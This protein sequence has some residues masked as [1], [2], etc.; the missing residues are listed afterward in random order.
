MNDPIEVRVV[1]NNL[2]GKD[3]KFTKDTM[4]FVN[5]VLMEEMFTLYHDRIPELFSEGKSTLFDDVFLEVESVAEGE[6]KWVK[7]RREF[8]RKAGN[9]QKMN[10]AN[11]VLA[12]YNYFLQ[13]IEAIK[14]LYSKYLSKYNLQVIDETAVNEGQLDKDSNAL[15]QQNSIEISSKQ[16]ATADIRLLIGSLKGNRFNDTYGI[17]TVVDFGKVFNILANKLANTKT[18][19]DKLRILEGL[20]QVDGNPDLL[21]RLLGRPLNEL[22]K[23]EVIEMLRFNQVFS[24]NNNQYELIFSSEEDRYKAIDANV[25]TSKRRLLERWKSEIDITSDKYQIEG[26]KLVFNTNHPD[27]AKYKDKSGNLKPIHLVQTLT[28]EQR[29]KVNTLPSNRRKQAELY[30]KSVNALKDIGIN[31]TTDSIGN[32]EFRERAAWIIDGIIKGEIRNIFTDAGTSQNLNII[33]QHEVDNSLDAI[34]NQHFNLEG[35]TVYNVNLYSYLTSLQQKINDSGS[36]VEL[37]REAPHLFTSDF[38]KHSLILNRQGSSKLQYNKVFDKD[39]NRRRDVN[40]VFAEGIKNDMDGSA[41]MF[42]DLS[43]VDKAHFLF[44]SALEGTHPVFRAGDN[45]L[46]RMFTGFEFFNRT[47]IRSREYSQDFYNYLIDEVSLAIELKE[48]SVKWNRADRLHT[49]FFN[50]SIFGPIVKN[51][52]IL[53]EQIENAITDNNAEILNDPAFLRQFNSVFEQYLNNKIS[54]TISFLEENMI[55]TLE[56]GRYNNNGLKFDQI[57]FSEAD[58]R[59][60]VKHMIINRAAFNSEQTKLISGHPVF[61]KDADDFFKRMS[62]VVGT[63]KISSVGRMENYIIDRYFPMLTQKRLYAHVNDKG[64]T[65]ITNQLTQSSKPVLRVG[66]M[67]DVMVQ[68]AYY[69]DLVKTINADAYNGMA[70]SDAI[71]IIH[72]DIYREMKIR[73]DNWTEAQERL[74][75]WLHR[76]EGESTIMFEDWTTRKMVEVGESDLVNLDGSRTVFT[77]LKPQGFGPNIADGF[78]PAMY[79]LSA[80]PLLPQ[81]NTP[82]F[83]ALREKMEAENIGLFTFPSANKVGTTL[84]DGQI[85][86]PYDAY[87]NVNFE[88][89]GIQ[90]TLF[91]NWGLQLETGD[92]FKRQSPKGSQF[93]KQ[94]ASNVFDGGKARNKHLGDLVNELY[95]VNEALIEKGKK[96]L[97]NRLGLKLVD[98]NYTIDSVKSLVNFIRE[99]SIKRDANNNILDSLDIYLELNDPFL[100]IDVISNRDK[101]ENILASVADSMVISQNFHGGSYVQAPVTFFEEGVRKYKDGKLQSLSETLKFYEDGT[102][103]IMIPHYFKE[104]FDGLTID[105]VNEMD[106]RLLEAVGFRIPTSGLNSIERVKI[107]GFLPQSAGEMVVLPSEIV[108][109]AGSGYG[110]DILNILLPNYIIVSDETL[111]YVEINKSLPLFENDKQALENRFTE[112]AKEIISFPENR[113]HLLSSVGTDLF[114]KEKNY[115][116]PLKKVCHDKKYDSLLFDY[117]YYVKVTQRN[118]DSKL[119]TAIGVLHASDHIL[120]TMNDYKMG[121]EHQISLPHNS[122]DDLVSLAGRETISGENISKI[123]DQL[124]NVFVDGAKSP[125]GFDLNVSLSTVGTLAYLIRAGVPLRTSLLFLNQPIICRYLYLE[126]I[127]KSI[128][129][130]SS[131][132]RLLTRNSVFGTISREFG[133]SIANID[134][135]YNTNMLLTSQIRSPEGSV[136]RAIFSEY[137][138]L[139]ESENIL[140]KHMHASRLDTEAMGKN[141]SELDYKLYVIKK[142][143]SSEEIVNARKLYEVGFIKPYYDAVQDFKNVLTPLFTHYKASRIQPYYKELLEYVH[144]LRVP[145][146]DKLRI[147]DAYKSDYVTAHILGGNFNITLG[148]SEFNFNKIASE[149]SLY[150]GK[151]TVADRVLRYRKQVDNHFLNNLQP[152]VSSVS[153]HGRFYKGV[154]MFDQKLDVFEINQLIDGWRDLF[155]KNPELAMDLVKLTLIQSGLQISPVT[156]TKIIPSEIYMAVVKQAL[157]T[158]EIDPHKFTQQFFVNNYN[159]ETLVPTARRGRVP[160]NSIVYKEWIPKAQS[161]AERYKLKSRG[162]NPYHNIPALKINKHMLGDIALFEGVAEIKS[163]AVKDF[164]NS[165][166]ILYYT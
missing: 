156:F 40:I 24:K 132:N 39:G 111:K 91:E 73:S 118:I 51:N 66:V 149:E 61:Y 92:S 56:E 145:I 123:L 33:L 2:P 133:A 83:N 77:P 70:E 32:A 12:T 4:D 141:T 158:G 64:E 112:V 15:W 98:G 152:I 6:M 58:L 155:S 113:Q 129:N 161:R 148:E 11:E 153:H 34:E 50:N 62:A 48:S 115:I 78:V 97:I 110:Y 89:I 54:D 135:D 27:I 45:S 150:V 109:K 44:N 21:S 79:K 128:L 19:E 18:L 140:S 85:H 94:L 52:K 57:T 137:L 68:S 67:Q 126:S 1:T 16:N 99:E 116:K 46:E 49:D 124:V 151:N 71:S 96:E 84:V 82:A 136:Q 23:V 26:D 36:L 59:L 88:N 9:V 86:S 101:I 17:Q 166:S 10:R 5:T 147:L 35:K 74:Y 53:K 25:N 29:E 122:K 47:H 90:D 163:S 138:R 164:R 103:E 100:G 81:Y 13:N 159:L 104:K 121:D 144:G 76:P 38:Q 60:A 108:A 30:Y 3:A 143:L 160:N 120:A 125:I 20:S 107:V 42:K 131:S 106:P 69:D 130:N 162:I 157:A 22:S 8:H 63:K 142:I 75:Q 72:P 55:V 117:P 14:S 102:M 41:T 7:G 31:I 139:R 165:I 28:E 43:I 65:K 95:S 146:A 37:L 154:K 87:G 93:V 105:V 134:L 119:C 127:R 80:Y 114:V